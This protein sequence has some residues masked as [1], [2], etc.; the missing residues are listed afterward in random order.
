MALT[1]WANLGHQPADLLECGGRPANVVTT[2]SHAGK[3]KKPPVYPVAFLMPYST[4]P[5]QKFLCSKKTVAKILAMPE[6][7]P[8]PPAALTKGGLLS[9]KSF[10]HK[11]HSADNAVNHRLLPSKNAQHLA[12][13][14]FFACKL[15]P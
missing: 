7:N 5:T 4:G 8:P 9:Y 11:N 15:I 6:V 13:L 12:R 2:S 3:R 10:N 1:T 14:Y